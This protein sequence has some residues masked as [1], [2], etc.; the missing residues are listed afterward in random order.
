MVKTEWA[1]ALQMKAALI[2]GELRAS[3]LKGLEALMN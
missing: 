3:L 1:L 2:D